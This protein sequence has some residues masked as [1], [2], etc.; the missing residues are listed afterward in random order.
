[1]A[2]ENNGTADLKELEG[3]KYGEAIRELEEIIRKMESDG[4]DIDELAGLTS[5]AMKL[6]KFC[7][8]RLFTTNKEVEDS[9]AQLR[10]MTE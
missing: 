8:T 1:M 4:C 10:A 2:Q 9:L 3:M 5:R 7:K 6:L